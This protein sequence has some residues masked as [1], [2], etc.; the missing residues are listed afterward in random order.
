MDKIGKIVNK[1]IEESFNLPMKLVVEC[2]ISEELQYHLN[3]EIPKNENVLRIY[4]DK[5]FKQI[6]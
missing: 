3:N 2:Y 4:T 1:I 5:Y 6:N